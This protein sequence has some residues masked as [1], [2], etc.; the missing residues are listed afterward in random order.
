LTIETIRMP[1][2]P[3]LREPVAVVGLPGVR[4]VGAAAA[5][6]LIERLGAERFAEMYSPALS[7]GVI[8]EDG[9][10]RL[11]RIE[12]YATKTPGRD[13]IVVVGDELPSTQPRDQYE[14][15]GRILDFLEGMGCSEVITVD[16]WITERPGQVY[17]AGSAGEKPP[18][19]QRVL[20]AAGV[21]LGLARIRGMRGRCVLVST[22]LIGDRDA[23]RRA[24]RA[25]VGQLGVG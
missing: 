10:A 12:F 25:V 3:D 19:N 2:A 5:R 7:A 1:H 15:C 17:V 13:V 6:L 11:P 24:Y 21:L 16:G 23:G 22:S 4:D 14:L 9:V 20:G 8:V 18:A